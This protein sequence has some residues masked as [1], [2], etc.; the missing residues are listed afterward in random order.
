MPRSQLN[1]PTPS[2]ADALD[3]CLS[4]HLPPSTFKRNS[5][6]RTQVNLEEKSYL[7][8]RMHTFFHPQNIEEIVLPII[9]QQT[10]ISLRLLDWLVT[11]Y[12]KK[13]NVSY[14]LSNNSLGIPIRLHE[15][16]KVQLKRYGKKLFDPFRRKSRIYFY[17]SDGEAPEIVDQPISEKDDENLAA[18]ARPGKKGFGPLTTKSFGTPLPIA[19]K[20]KKICSTAPRTKRKSPMSVNRLCHGRALRSVRCIASRSR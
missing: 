9:Q 1:H 4:I 12:A 3:D 2:K 19:R 20:S 15:S 8:G 5:T 11:N 13:F 17:Y 6:K 18:P 14:N 16:Y 7:L 10:K